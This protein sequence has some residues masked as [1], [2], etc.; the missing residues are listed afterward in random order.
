MIFSNVIALAVLGLGASLASGQSIEVLE[1]RQDAQPAQNV[2]VD[3]C[4]FFSADGYEVSLPILNCDGCNLLTRRTISSI[5]PECWQVLE[6]NNHLNHWWSNNSARCA[7]SNKGFS[8]CYLDSAGL[9]SWQCDFVALNACTPPPSGRDAGYASYQ[10]FYVSTGSRFHRVSMLTMSLLGHLEHLC[11][12]AINL[13]WTNYHQ[14][15]LQGQASA[16]GSVAEIVKTVAPPTTKHPKTPLFSPIYLVGLGQFAA[17]APLLGGSVA[18]S[19]MFASLIGVLGGGSGLFNLLFPTKTVNPVP[20]EGLSDALG[21]NVNEYQKNVGAALTE[22][23]TNFDTFYALTSN[24]GFSQRLKTNLP[25]DTDFMYHNLNK[26]VFNQALQQAG[27]FAVKN[28]GVDPREIPIDPYDCS[29]LDDKMTCG[30]IWFDGK[31]SYGLAKANDIGMDRMKEILDVAFSK[32][33]TTP[34]ELYIDAQSCRGKNGSE[35]FDV[36]DLTLSCVSNLPVCEFNFD[37]NPFETTWARVN[38][39]QF[40][41]C[42]NMRGWGVPPYWSNDAGVP[43]TYIGPFLMSGV[44]YNEK[45]G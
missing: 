24:G 22:I 5:L 2:T 16:I 10:E 8:Q 15:L 45:S 35:A 39:P 9:I 27:Y 4:S 30:P 32:N 11:V 44:I 12:L 13:F 14:S 26:W 19:M 28:P 42:P 3:Q 41:N 7:A 21:T 1:T 34:S 18:A 6:M 17:L 38:P 33:W 23:Q 40:T 43:L 25:E 20:W 31:D 37:Y 29:K 36:K